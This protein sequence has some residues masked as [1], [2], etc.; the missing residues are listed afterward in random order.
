MKYTLSVCLILLLTVISGCSKPEPPA[1]KATQPVKKPTVEKHVLNIPSVTSETQ[2]VE[3][4][5]QAMAT[6]RV[7]DEDTGLPI[8]D[9][10]VIIRWY[11]E[12]VFKIR[13][14]YIRKTGYTM[15]LPTGLQAE[16]MLVRMQ[17]DICQ[18]AKTI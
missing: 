18:M 15:Y 6:V 2:Y 8:I 1:A 10:T 13:L 16:F 17:T 5:P 3:T 4:E 12:N 7:T 11:S 9:A 14:A